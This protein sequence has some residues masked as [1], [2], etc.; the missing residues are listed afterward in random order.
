MTPTAEMGARELCEELHGVDPKMWK[1]NG[2]D[3][4]F[5]APNDE[6]WIWLDGASRPECLG[7][8]LVWLDSLE[9]RA[10]QMYCCDAWGWETGIA[11]DGEEKFLLGED[12]TDPTVALLR[13]CVE[14]YRAGALPSEVSK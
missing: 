8:I 3:F 12:L 1:T 10:R 13:L 2:H 14:L 7:P 9:Y 4:D 11:V 6:H 5:I